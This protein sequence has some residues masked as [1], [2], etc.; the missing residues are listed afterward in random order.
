MPLQALRFKPGINRESTTLGNEGGWFECDKIRFRSGQPEK[1]GGWTLDV[2]VQAGGAT[3]TVGAY[4]GVARALRNWITLAGQNLLGVG[5]DLKYYVQGGVNGALNDVTPVRATTAA[6]AITFAATPGSSTLVVNHTTHGA[7]V[8]DFVI[9]SGAVT[10]GGTVL[11]AT[12]NREY[13]IATVINANSYTVTMAVTANGLDVGSGGASTVGTYL[14]PVGFSSAVA[15]V[16]WGSGGWGGVTSGFSNTGWGQAPPVSSIRA[17]PRLW[18]HTN[19]GQDLILN[20][21]GGALYY[22]AVDA[23]PTVFNR[24]TVLT[25]QTF[26]VTI[27]SPGVVT[28]SV[29]LADGTAVT[30]STTGALPTG[31]AAGGTYYVVNGVNLA[32]ARGGT[33]INTSGS[34]SGTHSLV[35]TD[36]P[37]V[38]NYVLVSDNSRFV[39]AFGCNDLGTS[40]QDPMLIRWSDQED[41]TVWYPQITNQAG[42]FRLSIGSQII[43][44]QQTRQEVLVWTDAALYSMQYLGPPYVWGVQPLAPNISIAGPNAVATANNTTYWMGKD[45]FYVYTGQVQ[46]LPCTLWKYVFTDINLEQSYQFFAGTNEAYGEIWWFYCSAA[47]ATVDRY[48]IFNYLENTWYY[49]RLARTAWADSPLRD[50]PIAA[51][52]NGQIIYHESS[53][54][55]GT[56]TP[57]SPIAAFIQSSDFDIGDG[58]NYGFIWRIIPDLTFDGSTVDKPSATF[59]VRPRRNPGAP[60]G[61]DGTPVAQS[62]DNYAVDRYYEVQQFTQ[63]LY[64]RVRGRQMAL[65][66]SSDGLGTQ[67]Q[68]GV[69]RL[70]SRPDGRAG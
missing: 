67:W 51:G 47:S 27:A 2:G 65:R 32:T 41:Y 43:T 35:V 46:T 36:C 66:I 37:S 69:P 7:S 70:D 55:D 9:F 56:T 40:V 15:A 10:L 38:A 26:T 61:A 50:Y 17:Q 22:W 62:Q 8:G 6:G 14:L 60:Y 31:L 64:T 13:R 5:T 28:F 45:K 33:A 23:N 52:Y 48:V 44:A 68:L 34:Q 12:L 49:G 42:S 3:P 39:L 4:W 59:T 57:P 53:V 25:K 63:I 30:L 1:I 11:S 24:A 19:F 29:P 20:Y 18:S 58:H 21:R 16:G 54:D